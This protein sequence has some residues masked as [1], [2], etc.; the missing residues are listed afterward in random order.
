[1]WIIS[2]VLRGVFYEKKESDSFKNWNSKLLD[3]ILQKKI[4][5]LT[6]PLSLAV[7]RKLSYQL[8]ALN[9]LYIPMQ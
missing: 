2:G 8:R 4:F 1:M 7:E 9:I 5:L 3:Q 6:S